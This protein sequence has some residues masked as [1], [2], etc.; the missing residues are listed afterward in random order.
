MRE[1]G[2]AGGQEVQRTYAGSAEDDR[3]PDKGI[4]PEIEDRSEGGPEA[5]EPP[6][7]PTNHLDY[8]DRPAR[9]FRN[10]YPDEYLEPHNYT[11]DKVEPFSDPHDLAKRVN[12][13]LETGMSAYDHNCA[14]C[15]RCYERAWRGNVEEAAGRAY[16]VEKNDLVVHG[17][18][19]ER[20]EEWAG[21]QFSDVY[22][23]DDLRLRID[24][25][26]HGASAIVFTDDPRGFGHAYN[27]VNYQGEV[28][29]VDPQH[30]EVYP[31]SER[32]IHPDLSKNSSHLAMAWNAK[33]QRIW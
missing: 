19:A 23:V 33:G 15:A 31:W 9:E 16:V 7:T 12:P 10:H 28:Q 2:G 5:G 24:Y 1:L 22:D 27:V 11:T 8:K 14:D 18:A 26:G 20:T 21:E 29:V 25:A 30:H 6:E 32:S 4:A 13:D 3:S 17:E